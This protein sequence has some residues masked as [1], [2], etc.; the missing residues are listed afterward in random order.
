MRKHV[1]VFLIF[2]LL[3]AILF[4]GCDTLTVE[5]PEIKNGGFDTGNANLPNEWYAD[6][7]NT[8]VQ[9]SAV[10]VQ[11]VDGRDSCAHITNFIAN[12]YRLCQSV[13]VNPNAYYRISCDVKTSNVSGGAGANISI[14]DSSA[15]S[16][17]ITGTTQWQRV[18]LVGKT[19]SDQKELIVAVRLGGYG[20]LSLGEAWFDNFTI[21][22][23]DK[24]PS[25]IIADFKPMETKT[26]EK[27]PE[28]GVVPYMGAMILAVL[29]SGILFILT[30]RFIITRPTKGLEVNN[31]SKS[32]I[33]AILGSAFVLRVIL[34][35]IFV[36]HSTDIACFTSWSDTLAR[37]GMGSFYTTTSFCDYPPGYMYI[38]WIVGKVGG[39]LGLSTGSPLY[40]ILLKLPSI[41]ADL[42]LAYIVYRL[43]A[44]R[45]SRN[46]TIALTAI[47]ALN[48]AF[49][50]ISGGW[51]QIDQLLGISVF[52]AAYLFMTN[53]RVAAGAVYGLAILLKP[54]ALMVGP[55]FAV[56]YVVY[57][58]D[59][60]KD[61][62]RSLA[63]TAL[64][65][66]SAVALIFAATL[67]FKGNQDLFWFLDKYVNTA[68]SYGY[69]SVEAF[70]LFS[71]FGGNWAKIDNTFLLFSYG[72]WGTIFIALSCLYSAFL[73]IK[74][75]KSNQYCLVLCAALLFAALFTTGHY[76]HE[77]YLF[78]ALSLL[79]IAFVMYNDKRL[80]VAFGWFS[81]GLLF[82]ALAAFVII[83]NQ[84]A[85]GLT[86]DIMTGVGSF[87][88]VATFAYFAY[89]CTD[90]MV[91]KRFKSAISIK[92]D[93]DKKKVKTIEEN[94]K[95]EDEINETKVLPEPTDNKLRLTKRDKLFCIGLTAV[96]AVVALLNLGSLQAPET[97]WKAVTGDS[98]VISFSEAAPAIGEIRVFGGLYEGEFKLESPDG[99]YSVTFEQENGDMYRWESVGKPN[100]VIDS[101][102]L[103]VTSGKIWLNEIAFFDSNGVYIPFTV[104]ANAH[105]LGDEPDQVP[106]V[107]SYLNGMYFD[108][109]YHGRTAYEHLNGIS[110]YENSHPPLG[111]VIISI[112]IAIFGMNTIGWR[113]MGVLFGIGMVPIMY[114]FGKRL[115]KKSEFAL[116]AAG[117]F[118]FDFMHF[119]QTRIATID[120]YGVF[121]I[122]LMFYYMYQYYCMNF[123][124]DGLKK[125]LKP[126]ALA[127]LFFGLGAASKW[128]CFYAG[129]GLAIILFTS[130]VKR[131]TEYKQCMDH[132][133]A[134]ER[135]AVQG[136]WKKTWLTLGWCCV[137]YIAVPAV[138]YLASYIPY[139]V[140]ENPYTVLGERRS[141]WYLQE[142]MYDYHSGLT[143]TH[144][145][146]SPWYAWPFAVRP[147]LYYVKYFASGMK[148]TISAFG[149]PAVWWIC[150]ILAIGFA[151]MLAKGKFK[152]KKGT[153]IVILG[154][155]ANFLPWLLVTRCTF[156]YHFF[157]TVPFII[158]AAVYVLKYFE[159][160]NPKLAPIKWI[161]LCAA[162]V[163]FAMF[164]P[165]ISGVPVSS[166][167]I[168]WLM[169]LPGWTF[170]G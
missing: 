9:D 57:I 145:Y 115:F 105:A 134:K 43:A 45:F 109:L 164:Y 170:L 90:I 49:A 15:S 133:T 87:M 65:V 21:E 82:N 97:E 17:A 55:L 149:N 135:E 125:T 19:A 92:K 136:Y 153:F 51:G 121:F 29:L 74:G 99:S 25:G 30:Y 112:G 61:W 70:N 141:V 22:A 40:I 122:L 32:A 86:Y 140:C 44:K 114:V 118:T 79:I 67:P 138:I 120:T 63:K 77:R 154:I 163:L 130:L 159:D 107:P 80:L 46:V 95:N 62:K 31:T 52:A 96:Y 88:N 6:G 64:A 144:G 152:G 83:D 10:D 124:V 111:K 78:P 76:M 157:A 161:W 11:S 73:Y 16:A 143:E 148:G 7:W 26:E 59:S 119:T 110:P 5:N 4:T 53:R 166:D 50:F 91:R 126:L 137:F 60:G 81:A 94:L 168:K 13:R 35:L 123:H 162:V 103:T 85:R 104:S 75:R 1:V 155:C 28:K 89:V 156:A 147:V 48:L 12:D 167:Y 146:A 69:A 160:R 108:E 84:Q 139:L 117:L 131:Y 106:E 127:G 71:L 150:S 165:V 8:T 142:F 38:L 93:K 27:E 66:V 158:F 56:A 37:V 98:A 41:L 169:W 33:I 101:L 18:E 68:T 113:I 116:L 128:I 34:S 14:I 36:G 132:G 102:T 3:S 129:A 72:T 58:I 24:A 39:L 54:Q 47:T 20:M 23:L 100:R 42:A 2:A 151:V